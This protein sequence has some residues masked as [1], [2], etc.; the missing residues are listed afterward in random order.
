[1]LNAVRSGFS[2][3]LRDIRARKNIESYIVSIIA[4]VV[5]VV[6]L[7]DDVVPESAKTSVILAALGLLV[8][9]MTRPEGQRA[10]IEDYLHQRHELGPLA[11]R[12]N[13]AQKLWIYA[14]SAANVL[15]GDNLNTLRASILSD[16]LG[17]LRVVIQNPAAEDAMRVLKHQLDE[18]V[19]YPDQDLVREIGNTQAKFALIAGWP[20]K[21][22]FEHRLLSHSPGFSMVIV[23]PHRTSGV[24]I[25]ELY[26]WRLNSTSE[27]MAIEIKQSDSPRWFDYWVKQYEALWKDSE[28][29]V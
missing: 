8:F 13:G 28:H 18:I 25:V 20:K 10:T 14:P 22:T 1:M 24:A 27:R 23:D 4:V 26:G 2:R 17:E 19:G 12:L 11:A 29:P 7:I 21:G 9:N 5:A 6:G 16:S 15:S 3:V